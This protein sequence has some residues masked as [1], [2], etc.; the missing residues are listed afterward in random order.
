MDLRPLTITDISQWGD[1]LAC[2]FNQPVTYM[3][4]L[5]EW[6]YGLGAI[7][8][9][10]L[11]DNDQLIAQYSCL[12]R[13]IS[14]N[15]LTIPL[16]MSMNMA[17]HSDYRGQGLIKRVSQPVY[18]ILRKKQIAFGMGF[19]NAQGVKVDK[20]SKSYGY[21]VIG[22]MQPTIV[23]VRDFKLPPLKPLD[24]LPNP[25]Y[26]QPNQ[27]S[28]DAHFGKDT[29]HLIRRYLQHPFRH[30]QY[31]IWCEHDKIHGIVVYKTVN[32]RGIPAVA[33]LDV[34][35]QRPAELLMRWSS[36]LH[37]N[38][39]HLIHMLVSPQSHIKQIIKQHFLTIHAP[40]TCNPYYLTVK[41]LV[42]YFDT[43]LLSF[44]QWDLIGGDIL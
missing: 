6:L 17:V 25:F 38:H 5:V 7:D 24:T 9:Y 3:Q 37:H 2:C 43:N 16:G 40:F 8:A 44:N 39:I 1:L 12:N 18:E 32:L 36:T 26:V 23:K 41:P 33:L 30:Y 22:K 10:G 21:Q 4:Q 11:W 20:H 35:G 15:S 14:F 19:S 29:N 28:T 31:G 13:T 34:Y 27:S 42:S